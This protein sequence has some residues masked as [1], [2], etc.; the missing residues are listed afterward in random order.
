MACAVLTYVL[1]D[2]TIYCQFH[3]FGHHFSWEPIS[4]KRKWVGSCI[5]LQRWN[6]NTKLKAIC[7]FFIIEL[8]ICWDCSNFLLLLLFCSV[9]NFTHKIA[10]LASEC[11]LSAGALLRQNTKYGRGRYTDTEASLAEI[12]TARKKQA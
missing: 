12:G 10:K 1:T 9:L 4:R 8:H 3:Y 11:A 7:E 5:W 2:K 6:R